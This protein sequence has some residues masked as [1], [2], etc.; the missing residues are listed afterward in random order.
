MQVEQKKT[1]IP[2]LL[3]GSQVNYYNV[4]NS[5]VTQIKKSLLIHDIKKPFDKFIRLLRKNKAVPLYLLK[6][7]FKKL[8]NSKFLV[9]VLLILTLLDNPSNKSLESRSFFVNRHT[10]LMSLFR[11]KTELKISD[12][13]YFDQLLNTHYKKLLAAVN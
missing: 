7:V 9:L 3:F 4:K 1:F 11:P 13:Q 6:K 5:T 2:S 8:G 10:E 12:S